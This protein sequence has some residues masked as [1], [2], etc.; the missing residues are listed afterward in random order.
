MKELNK[1]NNDI[2]RSSGFKQDIFV[3]SYRSKI[4][5]NLKSRETDRAANFCK[6]WKKNF[7]L[8]ITDSELKSFFER[9]IDISTPRQ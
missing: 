9:I 3:K 4:S 6:F 2:S 7:V 5:Q 1:K 8:I